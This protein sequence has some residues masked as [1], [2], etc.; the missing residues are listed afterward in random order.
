MSIIEFNSIK[1]F[2]GG[3]TPSAEEKQALFREVLIMTLARATSSD[4]N[5]EPVEVETVR[6]LIRTETKEDIGEADIRVAASSAL[7]ETTPLDKFLSKAGAKLDTADRVRVVRALATV[8]TSDV[9]VSGMEVTFFNMVAKALNVSPAEL[10]GL[11]PP[12]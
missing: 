7:F 4:T 5:I 8:I 2:F 9:R 6:E 12:A 11:I 3:G 10:A 1:K